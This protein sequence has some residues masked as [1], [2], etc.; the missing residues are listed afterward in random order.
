M[1]PKGGFEMT[2]F[3]ANLGTILVTLAVIAVVAVII[4]RMVKEK[5]QGKSSCSHGCSNCAMHGRCHMAQT[6]AK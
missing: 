5:K 4:T 6:R 1:I 2:W 3:A